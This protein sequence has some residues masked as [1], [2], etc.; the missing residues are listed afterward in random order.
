MSKT[1]PYIDIH[2]HGSRK[3]EAGIVAIQSIMAGEMIPDFSTG[4][5][6]VGIHPWQLEEGNID[7]LKQQFQNSL[8][9][10]HVIA[11][12]EA[13]LDK[14][15]K[16]P[17]E[18]QISVFRMQIEM[19]EENKKPLIIHAVR[20][21]GEIIQLRKTTKAKTV[22][23]VHGFRGGQET[24]RQLLNH[25]ISLSFGAALLKENEKL[26]SALQ[27]VP[28][29]QL[30]LETDECNCNIEEIYQKAANYRNQSLDALKS[31]IFANF[32]GCFTK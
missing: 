25:G 28:N 11:I 9:N 17:L 1:T 20:V 30:F 16:T 10:T 26:I 2:S 27:I 32:A 7:K 22:W 18:E 3:T 31:V 12:G 21:F 4:F 15:I 24:A 14:A 23:I 8:K 6:S 19:A 29:E 13:G 5:F